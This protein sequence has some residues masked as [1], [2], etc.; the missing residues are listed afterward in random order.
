MAYS[1]V[2]LPKT[3]IA[4][5][6]EN[7]RSG[8]V[9]G[10]LVFLMALPLCLGIAMASRLPPVSGILSA[11]IGGLVASRINDSFITINGPVAGLIVAIVAAAQFSFDYR[12]KF[13]RRLSVLGRYF[14]I[15]I[16]I[17]FHGVVCHRAMNGLW[18]ISSAIACRSLFVDSEKRR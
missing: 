8:L 15:S 4:G 9:L 11:I 10:F 6:V 5:F 1:Q 12:D 14:L 16:I 3:G 7:W 17:R 2:G 18:F 13:G